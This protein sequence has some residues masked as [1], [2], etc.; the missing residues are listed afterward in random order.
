MT[1]DKQYHRF[2]ELAKYW[3]KELDFY[4]R[5]QFKRNV[6][7]S[8]WS[9]GQLYA[10]LIENTY[11][12]NIKAIEKCLALPKGTDSEKGKKL[13]GIIVFKLGFGWIKKM[14]TLS[15]PNPVQPLSPEKMKDDFYRFL[16]V[17]YNNSKQIDLVQPTAKVEHPLFGYLDAYEWLYLIEL[18]FKYHLNTKKK[19]DIQVRSNYKEM[20]NEGFDDIPDLPN[21]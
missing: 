7:E 14:K 18:H 17:V 12:I 4:G 13:K 3:L 15:N 9:V 21:E 10:H 2:L 5:N 20:S 19:L 6:F 8:K 16:K 1:A 11:E